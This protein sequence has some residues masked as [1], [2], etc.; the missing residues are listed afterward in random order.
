MPWPLLVALG[1]DIVWRLVE[2]F[3]EE[4]MS[5]LVGLFAEVRIGIDVGFGVDLWEEFRWLLVVKR[6]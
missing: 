3:E 6:K 4:R 2:W 1:S 5:K